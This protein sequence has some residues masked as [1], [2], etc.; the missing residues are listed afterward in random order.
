MTRLR[1][2]ELIEPN[3]D[4]LELLEILKFD[5]FHPSQLEVTNDPILKLLKNL[6]PQ[7]WALECLMLGSKFVTTA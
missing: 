5:K 2:K 4:V 3:G 6:K 7:K 1:P